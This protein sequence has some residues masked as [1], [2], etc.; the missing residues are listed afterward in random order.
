MSD[1]LFFMVL[2]VPTSVPQTL[3]P[4]FFNKREH[5]LNKKTVI[6]NRETVLTKVPFIR[7]KVEL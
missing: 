5:L 3:S 4:Y 6:L 2:E 1:A 7:G